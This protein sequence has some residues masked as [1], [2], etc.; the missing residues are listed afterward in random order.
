MSGWGVEGGLDEAA[1]L[2]VFVG[3]VQ[4]VLIHRSPSLRV[5][6]PV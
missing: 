2:G 3:G 1:E 6:A 5:H 4:E